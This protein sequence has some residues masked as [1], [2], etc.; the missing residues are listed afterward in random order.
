[1][2]AL[3]LFCC[4]WGVYVWMCVLKGLKYLLETC[5]L[6]W[7]EIYNRYCVIQWIIAVRIENCKIDLIEQWAKHISRIRT[8][9]IEIQKELTLISFPDIVSLVDDGILRLI[10]LPHVF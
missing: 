3:S 1:M 5:K 10:G 7:C 9:F 4:C 6:A 2:D 8:Y